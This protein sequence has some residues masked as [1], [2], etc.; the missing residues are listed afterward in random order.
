MVIEGGI[1]FTINNVYVKQIIIT[2]D[3]GRNKLVCVH[4]W[5]GVNVNYVGCQCLLTDDGDGGG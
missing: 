1:I 2:I 5:E 4:V 3:G